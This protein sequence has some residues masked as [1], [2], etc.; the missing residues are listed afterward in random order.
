VSPD[1]LA[2]ILVCLGP[3]LTAAEW[4]ARLGVTV[5]EVTGSGCPTR[6]DPNLG[7]FHRT[8]RQNRPGRPPV[9]THVQEGRIAEAFANGATIRE[10]A[11][12]YGIDR[13]TAASIVRRAA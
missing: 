7:N 13:T 4:A 12:V 3:D 5:A 6:P 8:G 9:L 11:L 1:D 2:R 10:I